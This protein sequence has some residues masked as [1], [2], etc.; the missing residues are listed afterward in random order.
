MLLDAYAGIYENELYG[1]ISLEKDKEGKGLVINF[2][3]HNNLFGKLQY[4][5]N[6]EWLLTYNN[7]GFGIFPIKFKTADKKVLSTELRVNEFIDMTHTTS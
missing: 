7:V 6:E 1:P 3:G 5:D 2:K 4:M